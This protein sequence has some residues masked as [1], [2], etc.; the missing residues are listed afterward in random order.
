MGIKDFGEGIKINK[1]VDILDDTNNLFTWYDI[2]YELD[3]EKYRLGD[4]TFFQYILKFI[5]FILKFLSNFMIILIPWAIWFVVIYTFFTRLILPIWDWIWSK[6]KTLVCFLIQE[7]GFE[8]WFLRFYPFETIFNSIFGD[9]WGC[10][11]SGEG[12]FDIDY[13]RCIDRFGGGGVECHGGYATDY[14]LWSAG[15]EGISLCDSIYDCPN[16]PEN[17]LLADSN[18]LIEIFAPTIGKGINF[19]SAPFKYLQCCKHDTQINGCINDK[20][21]AI[22]S[23]EY[24]NEIPLQYGGE[25]PNEAKYLYPNVFQDW[26]G[27]NFKSLNM[28]EATKRYFEKPRKWNFSKDNSR[29][30]CKELTRGSILFPLNWLDEIM[31]FI[32]DIQNFALKAGWFLIFLVLCIQIYNIIFRI[33]HGKIIKTAWEEKNNIEVFKKEIC[34]YADKESK[35][36]KCSTGFASNFF[37]NINDYKKNKTNEKINFENKHEKYI[38]ELPFGLDKMDL[39]FKEYVNKKYVD[40]S[41]TQDTSKSVETTTT[42]G[43]QTKSD[44]TDIQLDNTQIIVFGFIMIITFIVT[45]IVSVTKMLKKNTFKTN[46]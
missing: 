29:Q 20:I 1:F 36:G 31:F 21:N 30:N 35:S 2:C 14:T 28:Y 46:N 38:K 15:E 27:A 11:T 22:N 37:K 17:K 19:G 9:I 6:I 34:K 18:I 26:G 43:E 45:G 33:N 10:G 32:G 8:M 7:V 23:L 12:Q 42:S 24:S 44:I 39:L 13:G 4:L 41:I 40:K 3:T 5:Y 16:A 25:L